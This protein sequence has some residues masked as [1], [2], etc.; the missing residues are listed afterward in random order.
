MIAQL[1]EFLANTRQTLLS[2][3]G[4]HGHWEGELS[5]SALSTATAVIALEAVA[6]AEAVPSLADRTTLMDVVKRGREW[7]LSAQNA[8]GGW[9]DTTVSHSNISTTALVWAAL[10]GTDDCFADAVRRCEAWIRQTAGSLDPSQLAKVITA[11]YGTDHTFSV[12]ILTALALRGRL[13]PESDA[14]KLVPPLPFELA[15]FPH[16]W[17]ARLKLPVVS[18]ALPALIA[19]GQVR[20][21]CRPSLNPL[22]RITRRLAREKTLRV[23]REIQPASGGYL[24]ATPLT[25]FVVMS[26]VGAGNAEHEVVQHGVEF[27]LRS[28]RADGSWPIDTNLATWVTTL[29]VNALSTAGPLPG[30]LPGAEQR[31]ILEWLTSQQLQAEHP[32]THAAAGGW[33]WTDLTGGVPDADDTPGALLAL[34]NLAGLSAAESAIAGVK[35]L[36][37]LQNRDGGMPTFCRGWGVLPF[38]RSSADLTAHALRAWSVWFTYVSPTLQAR[39]RR[40]TRNA[41]SFLAK[42]QRP[43]G[44]WTPL[45]FG[46]QHATVEENLTYGTSRVLLALATISILDGSEAEPCD[47]VAS[48]KW[49]ISAQNADGGWGGG[50]GTPSSI[51]ETAL[52]VEAL[53]AVLTA[54]LDSDNLHQPIRRGIEWLKEHTNCGREFPP[55]PIGFY[56]AKL[57]YF[58]RMYPIVYTLAAVGRAATVLNQNHPQPAAT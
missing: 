43:D 41:L 12:P 36:L 50:E 19:I 24:E 5:S 46:N 18:Y 51:E 52:A 10:S 27:L 1:D 40:A 28:I 8:D 57:W 21:H 15:A 44:A 37:D 7:L 42:Q 29:A 35:W 17:Y 33:A 54:G 13:G 58:E 47:R 48:K 22:A 34:W 6:T 49:L 4:S 11:R 56:F 39:I 2:L 45:W 20:H 25:S 32:Y 38:D 23:L 55:S 3:R 31:P 26:L 14:W 30:S 9:G 53:C 16:A